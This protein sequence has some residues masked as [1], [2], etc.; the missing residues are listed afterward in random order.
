MKLRTTRQSSIPTLS[1]LE[2]GYFEDP[3]LGFLW[4]QSC[5]FHLFYAGMHWYVYKCTSRVN[6]SSMVHHHYIAQVLP[7]VH[8]SAC[9]FRD[10]RASSQ[11]RKRSCYPDSF[12]TFYAFLF[13]LCNLLF[14]VNR[15]IQWLKIKKYVKRDNKCVDNIIKLKKRKISV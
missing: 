7:S 5:I 2:K 8:V 15:S 6:W 13:N 9:G 10:L 14:T 1:R 4:V 3:S 12:R 11:C